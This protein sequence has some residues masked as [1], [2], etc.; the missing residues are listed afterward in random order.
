MS[1]SSSSDDSEEFERRIRARLEAKKATE[2]DSSSSDS[3][4]E[5]D[6]EE[7]G[8]KGDAVPTDT[9]DLFSLSSSDSS[10]S[11]K[12]TDD[13]VKSRRE[14]VREEDA[15]PT[16]HACNESHAATSVGGSNGSSPLDLTVEGCSSDQA[17][18]SNSLIRRDMVSCDGPA[19]QTQGGNDEVPTIG[20]EVQ[21]L[22]MLPSKSFGDT[23][24]EPSALW[25]S[26]EDD[27][28]TLDEEDFC[29]LDRMVEERLSTS[30]PAARIR[31]AEA[32]DKEST[33]RSTQKSSHLLD[34][35]DTSSRHFKE[36]SVAES[37]SPSLKVAASFLEKNG[38]SSVEASR[39]E[40]MSLS[41]ENESSGASDS[42]D[43]LSKE[44]PD[45]ATWVNESQFLLKDDLESK[46]APTCV[47]TRPPASSGAHR[48]V[49]LSSDPSHEEKPSLRKEEI[50]LD[51]DGRKPSDQQREEERDEDANAKGCEENPC[52]G[53]D[54]LEVAW[55]RPP[56]D[57]TFE[58][59]PSYYVPEPYK[60]KSDPLVHRFT[61]ANKP[62]ATRSEISISRVFSCPIDSLWKNKFQNFNHMQSELTNKLAYRCVC[63]CYDSL[64]FNV[65]ID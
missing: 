39:N 27:F 6:E 20:T 17:L 33:S 22:T 26:D 25:L 12:K 40:S 1:D 44:A 58:V 53:E 18:G 37:S 56:E 2:L 42:Q 62:L 43:A 55:P 47:V 60:P 32:D 13:P 54:V 52:G 19:T 11:W 30:A 46:K 45:K 57:R 61:V 59:H 3:E 8:A 16:S 36:R 31:S 7:E 9:V 34:T 63:C 49:A 21:T 4:S 5:T 29:E 38:S 15:K 28:P 41:K 10:I 64:Q 65:S 51:L 48:D 14:S 23:G 50:D 24:E 35:S